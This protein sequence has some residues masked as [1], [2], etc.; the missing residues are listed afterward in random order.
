MR[1]DPT[2][3]VW[4]LT[5]RALFQV[6]EDRDASAVLRAGRI[7]EL[8]R[9]HETPVPGIE[10]TV[11]CSFPSVVEMEEALRKGALPAGTGALL[12]DPENWAFTPMEEQV[13]LE[14]SVRRSVALAH[15]HGMLL[16]AT[17]AVTLTRVLAPGD[18]DRYSRYLTAGIAG[19][20]A[21]AD[22]VDVQ[23]QNAVRRQ[24]TYERVV[25][26]AAAQV[27]AANPAARVIAGLSTNPPGDPVTVRMLRRA[28]RQVRGTVDGFWL[29]IPSPGP[30]CPTCNPMRPEIAIAS[31]RSAFA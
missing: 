14:G 7:F 29:N 31:L 16:I 23:A 30:K 26:E 25:R 5:R 19:A 2:G 24:R 27:R 13:D 11:A 6:T 22:I 28:I 4:V 12:Y 20:A 15:A 21:S 10:A 8:L 1:A 17:P 18:G 3:L 9:P